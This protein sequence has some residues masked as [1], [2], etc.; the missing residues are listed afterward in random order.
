V[1]TISSLSLFSLYLARLARIQPRRPI[2]GPV[3]LLFSLRPP[4]PIYAIAFVECV[5]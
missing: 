2:V 4:W 3:S 1:L 5:R